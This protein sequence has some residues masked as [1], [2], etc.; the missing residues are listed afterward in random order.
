MPSWQW[1]T[2]GRPALQSEEHLAAEARFAALPHVIAQAAALRLAR[3]DRRR[4][5]RDRPRAGSESVELLPGSRFQVL[6]A[7]VPA[8]G[9]ALSKKREPSLPS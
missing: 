5:G 3:L 9:S 2:A 4:S 8:G 1:K 7:R 6:R